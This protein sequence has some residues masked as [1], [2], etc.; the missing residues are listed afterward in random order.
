MCYCSYNDDIY[1]CA[2]FFCKAFVSVPHEPLMNKITRL[3]SMKTSVDGS[4]TILSTDSKWLEL[5]RTKK[6][7]DLHLAQ[8]MWKLLA[9]MNLTTDDLEEVDL[10]FMRTLYSIR[11][12]HKTDICEEDFSEVTIVVI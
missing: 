1:I 12:V 6:P 2:V 7:L 9:G 11:D 5:M 3:I 10:L 8:P 4:E